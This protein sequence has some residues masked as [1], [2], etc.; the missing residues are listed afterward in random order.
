MQERRKC[1]RSRVLKSAKIVIGGASVIDCVVRNVT[2]GG[3]RLEVSNTID[4]PEILA[5]TFDDC[6]SFRD[7]RLAWRT[8]STVGV[9]FL[10]NRAA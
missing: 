2:S 1:A 6:H 10:E 9:Q 4:L 5:V 3:A 8:L 7:C